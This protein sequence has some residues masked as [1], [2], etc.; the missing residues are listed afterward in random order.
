MGRKGVGKARDD[1]PSMLLAGGLSLGL[2][3][4]C[5]TL[6]WN[7]DGTVYG[8]PA[9]MGAPYRFCLQAVLGLT[10]VV[11][12]SLK[13]R[14]FKVIVKILVPEVDGSPVEVSEAG[15]D[16]I[17]LVGYGAGGCG[18]NLKVP[19]FDLLSE[20]RDSVSCCI[21]AAGGIVD[22]VTAAAAAAAGADGVYCGSSFLCAEESPVCDEAKQ[23]ICETR[24]Q[25]MVEFPVGFGMMRATNTERSQLA[26]QMVGEGADPPP[27][28]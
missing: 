22:G 27:L 11:I 6:G 24:A 21:A 7:Q 3:F 26:L 9:Q 8:I 4:G 18:P 16:A 10:L 19:F 13:E 12:A 23:I 2:L 1:I 28:S 14:G 17:A 25:D 20:D 15:A 5:S